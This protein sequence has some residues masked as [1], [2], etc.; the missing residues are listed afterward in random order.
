MKKKTLVGLIV[1]IAV[2][3]VMGTSGCTSSNRNE[4]TVQA[5]SNAS[6]GSPS[7]A[8]QVSVTAT[9]LGSFNS[10]TT[11]FGTSTAPATGNKFV[12]YAMYFQN[13]NKKG[14]DMGN[15]YNVKLRDTQGN[16]YSFDSNT[17]SLPQQQVNG[18]TLKGLTVQT[19]T[20]PGD[21]YAG[22]IVFSIPQSATPKALIYDDYTNKVTINL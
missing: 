4:A 11:N 12:E 5:G 16:L 18:T 10:L 6:L 15:P 1:L 2:L 19:N 13:I 17:F 8:S 3:A 9:S 20:E 7:T 21:K 14:L 22:L